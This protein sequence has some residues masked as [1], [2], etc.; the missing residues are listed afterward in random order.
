MYQTSNNTR[1]LPAILSKIQ[2]FEDE[3]NSPNPKI[4]LDLIKSLRAN[5]TIENDSY[6]EIGKISR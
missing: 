2:E 6:L 5:S 4:K 3:E 1:L